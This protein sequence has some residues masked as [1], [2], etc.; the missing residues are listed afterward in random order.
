MGMIFLAIQGINLWLPAS[1]VGNHHVFLSAKTKCREI[2]ANHAE[3]LVCR[4][5]I[6][7]ARVSVLFF[8][9]SPL[10]EFDLQSSRTLSA[11][12]RWQTTAP[13]ARSGQ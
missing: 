6:F 3:Y 2:A 1:I 4:Q 13:Y 12:L 8:M 11:G 5:P 9:L 7:L 10:F